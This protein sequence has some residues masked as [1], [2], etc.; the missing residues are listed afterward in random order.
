MSLLLLLSVPGPTIIAPPS[1][2]SPYLEI[3]IDGSAQTQKEIEDLLQEHPEV[4]SKK[5]GSLGG[6]TRLSFRGSRSLQNRMTLDGLPLST[7]FDGLQAWRLIEPA[8]LSHLRIDSGGSRS[9]LTPLGG[10]VELKTTRG[11]GPWF[12]LIAGSN[13]YRHLALGHRDSQIRMGASLSQEQGDFTYFDNRG[14]LFHTEDD[15]QIRRQNNQR[16]P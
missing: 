13:A 12:Q 14:T 15:R 16:H 8:L 11:E 9:G 10:H 2:R 3:N 7:G 1:A 4:S 5:S 6:L